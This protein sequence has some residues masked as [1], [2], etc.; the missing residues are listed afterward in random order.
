[1]TVKIQPG[2]REVDPIG[3]QRVL[4]VETSV[5]FPNPPADAGAPALDAALPGGTLLA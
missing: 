1:M 2:C 5:R 4:E 3:L